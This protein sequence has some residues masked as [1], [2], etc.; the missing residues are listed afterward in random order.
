[1]SILVGDVEAPGNLEQLEKDLL[2]AS[3]A[4]QASAEANSKESDKADAN[5]SLPEKFRGKSANEIAAMYINLESIHGRTAND[6]GVQRK[7][8]DRLLNLDAPSKREADLQ[9][10]TPARVEVTSGD[11]LD[12]PTETIERVVSAREQALVKPVTDRLDNVERALAES[13]FL[14]KHADFATVAA[15]PEFHTWVNSSALRLRAANAAQQGN[16]DVADELLSEYK[17]TRSSSESN[18][19]QD[20]PNLSAARNASLESS[21]TSQD[22][23]SQ[24][25]GKIYSRASLIRLKMEKPDSYYDEAFQAEITKAYLEKRVK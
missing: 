10:N 17:S 24:K 22:A 9:R 19:K 13:R 4:S 6:L 2:E 25:A 20:N 18:M 5:D 7:L 16:Y 23:G 15:S 11:L 21:G 3:T 14:V 1:M 12:K 8:T